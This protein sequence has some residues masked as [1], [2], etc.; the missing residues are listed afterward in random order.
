MGLTSGGVVEMSWAL[1]N[2]RR[3]SIDPPEKLREEG[4]IPYIPE[5]P[6]Q[7]ET[8][9]NYNQSVNRI[10]GIHTAPSGLESTCLV[11]AYGLDIF[12][13]RVSPSKT[14]DLLKEDF[15]YF[16]ISVVLIGLTTAS[17]ITKYLSARKAIKQA[18]K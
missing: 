18:W 14:F 2:P 13:T 16:V 6:I 1:L 10:S 4:I 7:H 15:D 17:Y 9:I 5:L 12:V 3:N 8:I 11:I